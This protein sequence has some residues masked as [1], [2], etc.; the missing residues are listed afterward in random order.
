MSMT[1]RLELPELSE[2]QASKYLT[3]NEALRRLDGLVQAACLDRSHT[4]PPGSPNAGDAYIVA[5]P[6]T[7]DWTGLEDYYVVYD[8]SS[9][10]EFEPFARMIVVDAGAGEVL[11]WNEGESPPMWDV[12]A[13]LSG[14]LAFTSLT[15]TFVGYGGKAGEV[16][17]VTA[18]ED[19][20]EAVKDQVVVEVVPEGSPLE[21]VPEIADGGRQTV[22]YVT[23]VGEDLSVSAPVGSPLNYQKLVLRI[24][25]ATSRVL[26]FDGVYRGSVDL[27][28]PE[29]TS[30]GG[31]TDYFLFVYNSQ[32][33]KWDYI[34]QNM[35]F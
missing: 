16:L 27:A 8:G 34:A 26:E 25:S 11:M 17:R 19:G 7:G 31:K 20:I 3:H 14:S 4:A 22:C 9:W 29:E 13:T 1:P 10:D 33:S 24:K 28:L 23:A 18:G 15:D 21:I 12:F 6:A 30:G 2:S 32:D 5:A 35:G